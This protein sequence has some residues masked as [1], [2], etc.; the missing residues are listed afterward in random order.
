MTAIDLKDSSNNTIFSLPYTYDAN[1]N[2]TQETIGNDTIS[3]TYDALNRLTFIDRPGTTNDTTYT[4]DERGNRTEMETGSVTN[5]LTF[6][7]AD[8]L[9]RVDKPSNA[10]D[11]Y[12]YDYNGNLTQ[13]DR[14]YPTPLLNNS[15][16]DDKN[17]EN[18]TEN[19]NSLLMTHYPSDYLPSPE[20][21][22]DNLSPYLP[23]LSKI[24]PMSAKL[25]QFF[26]EKAKYDRGQRL[27]DISS[28]RPT[29]DETT[30]FTYSS[31]NNMTHADLTDG[32]DLDFAYD[33]AG[34]RLE[35]KYTKVINNVT[36]E[37]KYTYHYIGSQIT[38][39]DISGKEDETIT[40][41]DQMRIHLGANSRPIS[42]E[43]YTDIGTEQQASETYYYHYD[44]HGNV[45]RVT[46]DTG[47]TE[48]TY[49]YDSLGTIV[50]ET[51]ANSIYNPFTWSGEAQIIHDP[52]FNTSASSPITGL[53][54]SGSGYY[55]PETGTF[56]SGTGAPASVNP[57]SGTMEEPTAQSTRPAAQLG[58][59]AGIA[60][61]AGGVPVS[62]APATSTDVAPEPTTETTPMIG[63]YGGDLEWSYTSHGLT[64]AEMQMKNMEWWSGSYN[65]GRQKN[66][67]THTPEWEEKYKEAKQDAITMTEEDW[68]KKYPDW[69]LSCFPAGAVWA[70]ASTW[71]KTPTDVRKKIID[72]ELKRHP[73]VR[74]KLQELIAKGIVGLALAQMYLFTWIC[75]NIVSKLEFTAWGYKDGNEDYTF[76]DEGGKYIYTQKGGFYLLGYQL[77]GQIPH[78][79]WGPGK[80]SWTHQPGGVTRKTEKSSLC[81]REYCDST[82]TDNGP[83]G[84]TGP[85]KS[86]WQVINASQEKSGMGTDNV[87]LH[88][89][90][91]AAVGLSGRSNIFDLPA[92]IMIITISDGGV[93]FRER[94]HRPIGYSSSAIF[95]INKLIKNK[96][97][98]YFTDGSDTEEIENEDMFDLFNGGH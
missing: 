96:V 35:K 59:H 4:Y 77:S 93:S 13:M 66:G 71:I 42:F 40:R 92:E 89:A 14:Y 68:K 85:L 5:Y 44:L 58:L 33:A 81:G 61:V 50:S 19:G 32:S 29:P 98:I 53:Y 73:E 22:W 70:E 30:T 67:I 31:D 52:E 3:Y 97:S 47:T 49:T 7:V 74:G 37:T 23:D 10:Y 11:T 34:R 27:R 55:N 16:S 80:C 54:N 60:A 88:S 95:V 17:R 21:K 72:E 62:A 2:V 76:E 39:I 41:N 57:T 91:S 94:V 24:D 86:S 64:V 75:D 6:N 28:P 45:I 79:Y 8:R 1:G 9:T 63:I 69:Y 87:T 83:R 43:Y 78:F 15:A 65:D 82:L 36:Y 26:P 51:N 25:A 18:A 56:L 12:T 48:I 20:N 46:D 84:M 38:T 90:G